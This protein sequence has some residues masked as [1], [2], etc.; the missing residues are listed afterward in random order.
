MGTPARRLGIG[1]ETT[2]MIRS[3]ASPRLEAQK[4]LLG[5]LIENSTG[6][7]GPG[8]IADI[9]SELG[10]ARFREALCY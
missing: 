5:S 3:R 7:K 9:G 4:G 1:I 2:R 8:I 6:L 10:V